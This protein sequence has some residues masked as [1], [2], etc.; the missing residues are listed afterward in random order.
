MKLVV[1]SA[2]KNLDNADMYRHMYRLKLPN[3]LPRGLYVIGTIHRG[4]YRAG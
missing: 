2:Q 3:K 1:P 4:V